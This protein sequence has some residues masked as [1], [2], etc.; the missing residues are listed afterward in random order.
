MNG[1]RDAVKCPKCGAKRV[2]YRMG[3]SAG[4]VVR[5]YCTGCGKHFIAKAGKPRKP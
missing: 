2:I 3:A 4:K 5:N 1:Y